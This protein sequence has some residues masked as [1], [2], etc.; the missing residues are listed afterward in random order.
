MATPEVNTRPSAAQGRAF[1]I[2]ITHRERRCNHCERPTTT[3]VIAA[4]KVYCGKLCA[5]LGLI[6]DVDQEDGLGPAVEIDVFTCLVESVFYEGK[7]GIPIKV[8]YCDTEKA[9]ASDFFKWEDET[10]CRSMIPIE[11]DGTPD[12]MPDPFLDAD[13]DQVD[14]AVD[15]ILVGN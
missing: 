6:S 2:R 15:H 12:W 10:F 14:L 9:L 4:R 8:R 11:D 1:P 7:I 3:P 5:A 13:Q